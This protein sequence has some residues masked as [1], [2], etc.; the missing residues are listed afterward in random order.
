MVLFACC[1]VDIFLVFTLA[2]TKGALV[3]A[4]KIPAV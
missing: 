4:T 3:L 2:D 1:S